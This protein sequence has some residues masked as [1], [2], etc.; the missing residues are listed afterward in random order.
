MSSDDKDAEALFRA[1][2]KDARPLKGRRART[3]EE[4]AAEPRRTPPPVPAA[5]RAPP[6]PAAPSPMPLDPAS[7]TGIDRATADRLR[8]GKLEPD[9]RLDLHGLTLAEAE[10]ALARFLE[11]SQA[12]GCKLVLVITG[13]G[14]R[15]KDGRMTEGRIRAEFPHW[16]NRPEN[17]ARIHGVRGAHVR[18]GGGG[19]FYVMVR[20]PSR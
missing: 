14:L 3:A 6:S 10:R 15:Q 18:H 2:M 20:R 1:A 12:T 7:A 16:L 9:A 8:R 17:R 19:A 4:P 5:H 11:R 13:K